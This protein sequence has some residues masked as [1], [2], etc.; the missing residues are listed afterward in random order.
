MRSLA[1]GGLSLR[2][3]LA[4]FATLA[5]AQF[6]VAVESAKTPEDAFKESLKTGKPI[7]AV[8]GSET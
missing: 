4:V 8:L 3:G 1:S 6:A 7:L 5:C 2:L